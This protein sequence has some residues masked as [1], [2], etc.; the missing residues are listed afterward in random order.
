MFT[1]RCCSIVCSSVIFC[2]GV[3]V[4]CMMHMCCGLRWGGMIGGIGECHTAAYECKEQETGEGEN[5][6][7]HVG[8]LDSLLLF[9]YSLLRQHRNQICSHRKTQQRRIE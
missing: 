1:H 7:S 6:G 4:H 5:R 3:T 8:L 2:T 9:V